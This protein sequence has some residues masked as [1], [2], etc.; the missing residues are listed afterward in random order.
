MSENAA[1]EN[2]S[3]EQLLEMTT[4]IVSAYVGNNTIAAGELNELI[5]SIHDSL[6]N[7]TTGS[8]EVEPEP[9][10][11]AVPV[12]RSVTPD[13]L[14]CLEDGKRLKMLKRHLRTT[15]GLSPDDYRAK[16]GLPADYPMV[17][18][19]YAQ[20]RSEFAKK[21]GLGKVGQEK[22]RRGKG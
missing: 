11:P 10:K 3:K 1:P 9:I 14:I 22:R 15:Y 5:V 7:L 16:W 2:I 6:H 4:E 13:Y 17:A 8:V 21:I 19:N 12:R 20:Q 18:P